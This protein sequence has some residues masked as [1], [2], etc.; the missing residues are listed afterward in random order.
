MAWATTWSAGALGRVVEDDCLSPSEQLDDTPTIT[1]IV[2]VR[3][4][5][6]GR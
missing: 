3:R 4:I 1:R 2:A 5:R 6:D